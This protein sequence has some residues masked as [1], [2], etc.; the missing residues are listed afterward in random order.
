MAQFLHS[1]ADTKF[2]TRQE[3]STTV[4]LVL[5]CFARQA[6]FASCESACAMREC[7]ASLTLVL[8]DPQVIVGYA[9]CQPPYRS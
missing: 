4:F 3:R 2:F 6:D 1:F 9:T 7:Y 8:S 5:S